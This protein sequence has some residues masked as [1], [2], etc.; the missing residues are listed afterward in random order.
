MSKPSPLSDAEIHAE[1]LTLEQLR[2]RRAQEHARRDLDRYRRDIEYK[3]AL[4]LPLEQPLPNALG[5]A[6]GT[7]RRISDGIRATKRLGG[8]V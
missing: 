5:P 2:Q 8:A 3:K 6:G 4:G 7:R 1:I